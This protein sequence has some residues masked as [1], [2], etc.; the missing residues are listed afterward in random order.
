VNLNN[1]MILFWDWW[2]KHKVEVLFDV[3]L[4][5]MLLSIQAEQDKAIAARDVAWGTY[6]NQSCIFHDDLLYNPVSTIPKLNITYDMEVK[7]EQ[8]IRTDIK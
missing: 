8:E 7:N 4:L 6:I 1:I 3:F 5:L 2:K